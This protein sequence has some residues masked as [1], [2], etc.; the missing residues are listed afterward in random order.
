MRTPFFL[1]F[2]LLPAFVFGQRFQ[3]NSNVSLSVNAGPAFGVSVK[4]ENLFKDNFSYY[5]GLTFL[6][7][8][9]DI[10]SS[11]ELLTARFNDF[12]GEVGGRYYLSRYSKLLPF[13]GGGV[14]AG[15]EQFFNSDIISGAIIYDRGD[16][17]LYGA[18][19]EAGV[20]YNMGKTSLLISAQGKYDFSQQHLYVLGSV[21]LNFYF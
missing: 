14:F 17:Y 11:G 12:F 13:I 4:Y 8:T 2:I 18:G 6:R 21:G 16:S 3:G 19:A 7:D 10:E 9:D 1:F 5:A 15:Y 20:E